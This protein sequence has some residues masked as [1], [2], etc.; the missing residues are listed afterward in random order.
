MKLRD[1]VFRKDNRF[2]A[3]VPL[4]MGWYELLDMRK[5]KIHWKKRGLCHVPLKLRCQSKLT[6]NLFLETHNIIL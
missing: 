1:N 3:K 2:F 5:I 6:D 4:K